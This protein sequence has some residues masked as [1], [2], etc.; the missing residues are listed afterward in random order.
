MLKFRERLIERLLV[1]PGTRVDLGRDFDP[2]YTAHY[3]KK[4]DAEVLLGEGIQRLAEYQDK[5]WA[6]NTY[7]LLVILQAMDAAG[8]DGVIKH[9]MS[10]LNPQGCQVSSFK[11]PSP[12]ELGHDYLWRDS[13]VLPERGRIGIFNRSYYEEVL[14][15]RV[16]PE[17]LQQQQLPEALRSKKIWERRFEEINCFERYLSQ[18]GILVLKFF[19]Y[20]SREEQKR[21]FMTRIDT[22][23]KNWKFSSADIRERRYWNEYMKAYEDMLSHTSTPEAPWHIVPA[24]HKWFTRLAVAEVIIQKFVDIDPQYPK[25][26]A[27]RKKEL[28]KAREWLE[29][30]G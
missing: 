12:E 6:Q 17:V 29:Q 20:L 7:G 2:A 1:K 5:F 14:V 10:G 4:E 16:H 30:E 8:K 18:N 15:V 22:P 25:L 13:R 9:V 28:A 23:E 11:A 3:V 19:L 26:T 24:D 21:R 27:A